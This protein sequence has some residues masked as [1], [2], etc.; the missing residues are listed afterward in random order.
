MGAIRDWWLGPSHAKVVSEAYSEMNDQLGQDDLDAS[1]SENFGELKR[2]Q[3]A[4]IDPSQGSKPFKDWK[5][6]DDE[7]SELERWKRQVDAMV[8]SGNPVLQK[9]GLS[10][11]ASYRQRAT[12][13]EAISQAAP[14]T[15][16]KMAAEMGLK[17]GTAEWNNFIQSY[18]FKSNRQYAPKYVTPA[19]AK[20]LRWEDKD[21]TAPL[22][23]QDWEQIRGK[24]R[25]IDDGATMRDSA[26]DVIGGLEEMLNNPED[27]IYNDPV[28]QGG[29]GAG[30]VIAGGL[31]GALSDLTQNN[32]KYK[33]YS[34]LRAGSAAQI[35]RAMGEKGALSDKDIDRALALLPNISGARGMPDTKETAGIKLKY[36]KL[37]LGI[38][39]KDWTSV[40]DMAE[41]EVGTLAPK[42]ASGLPPG[43]VAEVN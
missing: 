28:W 16:A 13:P 26:M 40:I 25:T 35:V 32:P 5:D 6:P 33:A 30:Q 12:A 38:D 19:E 20:N 24:V 10:Q 8:N 15:A 34:D 22:V 27:G 37:M 11:L 18:A 4:G 1:F 42:P 36:L 41:A 31:T 39:P 3:A 9:E 7:R 17:P 29:S 2:Q 23:G 43:A 21:E 14:S